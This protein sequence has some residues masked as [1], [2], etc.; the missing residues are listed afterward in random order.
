MASVTDDMHTVAKLETSKIPAERIQAAKEMARIQAELKS[1]SVELAGTHAA[2]KA[3]SDAFDVT[4]S[5]VKDGIIG[6]FNAAKEGFQE[7]ATAGERTAPSPLRRAQSTPDVGGLT[8]HGAY[9]RGIEGGR[10]VENIRTA[11][12]NAADLAQR[13]A[14]LSKNLDEIKRSMIEH[15]LP[16]EVLRDKLSGRADRRLTAVARQMEHPSL[17][18]VPQQWKPMWDSITKLHEEAAYKPDLQEALKEVPNNWNTVLRIAAEQGFNPEHVRSFQPSEIRKLVFDSVSLGHR[19]RDVGQTIEAGTRK[20][21][22]AAQARTRS[23]SALAAGISEATHESHT[24]ALAKFIDDTWAKPVVNGEI[25]A[26]GVG[27]DAERSF[28]LTGQKTAEGT[29]RVAGLGAPTKWIPREVKSVLDAYQRD[30]HHGIFNYIRTATDPW[31]LLVLTLSPRW[32]VNHIIGHV[33]MTVKEGVNLGDWAKAWQAF[34]EGGPDLTRNR[35][36]Q[37]F[38]AGT[39][40]FGDVAGAVAGG[41]RNEVAQSDT[42]VPYPRGLEGLKM[43]KQ[44]GVGTALNMLSQ[45]IARPA[46]VVDELGRVA[47]YFNGVRKGMTDAEA[48]N[49]TYHA[50]VDFTDMSPAERQVVRSVVPFYAFQKGM[51]K[52]VSKFP[53]DH[54]IATSVAMTLDKVNRDLSTNQFGGQVPAYYQSMVNIPGLGYTPSKA[55]NPFA[56]VSTLTTPQGIANSLNP[57][58]SIAVRNALGAPSGAAYRSVNQFGKSVPDTSPAQDLTDLLAGLPQAKVAQAATGTSISGVPQKGLGEAVS[59]YAGLPTYSRADIQ[60]LVDKMAKAQK[61]SKS[62]TKVSARP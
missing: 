41:L 11:A 5:P 23:L 37:K 29:T 30:Y 28:L 53:I 33:M 43:A 55:F 60:A 35:F 50:L 13:R 27:W 3:A 42:L 52:I 14:D 16:S 61:T 21:R 4:R 57:F 45:R 47:T 10:A 38:G 34:R 17:S 54:P 2:A 20:T 56:D 48:L 44:E 12:Q 22:V 36:M 26:H 31:R 18:G 25:P 51:L 7:S 62:K 59:T 58:V 19:G 1:V 32:Y 9:R 39:N 40:S 8:Q 6:K 49:R 15:T 24:N 46:T